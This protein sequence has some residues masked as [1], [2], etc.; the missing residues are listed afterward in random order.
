MTDSSNSKAQSP[1][2]AGIRFVLDLGVPLDRLISLIVP[3]VWF[4]VAAI[5]TGDALSTL[6]FGCLPL[7][8]P[9]ALIWFSD[10]IGSFTGIFQ[11]RQV[12]QESPPDLLRILGWIGLVAII[13]FQAYHIFSSTPE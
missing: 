13:G 2:R 12:S 10:E 6:L 5:A 1:L 9:L 8:P 7:I 3:P 4:V 11:F